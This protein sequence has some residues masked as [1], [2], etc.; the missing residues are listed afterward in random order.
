MP[1]WT[2]WEL[3]AALAAVAALALLHGTRIVLQRAAAAPAAPQTAFLPPRAERGPV[4]QRDATPFQWQ[5]LAKSAQ[6]AFLMGGSAEL[7]EYFISH[8]AFEANQTTTVPCTVSTP[9]V[10][11]TE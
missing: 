4:G 7:V 5:E 9:S 2:W 11:A 8:D 6:Q 3:R 10:C 1:R